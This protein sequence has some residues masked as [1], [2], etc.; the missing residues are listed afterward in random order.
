MFI[1]AYEIELLCIKNVDIKVSAND[2]FLKQS[3]S[4]T[5]KIQRL[6]TK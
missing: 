1:Y 6:E 2:V 4:G 3:S 5:L